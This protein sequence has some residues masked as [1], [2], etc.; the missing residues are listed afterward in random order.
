M[1][2]RGRPAKIDGNHS[3]IRSVLR[4]IGAMVVD[5]SAVGS[6][7]PDLMVLYRGRVRLLEVKD[8]NKPPSARRLTPDQRTWHQMAGA[9]GVCVHVVTNIDE[10]VM[11]T[12]AEAP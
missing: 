9:R 11:A 12:C 6:G 8:G 2:S 4:D 1:I 7:V 5:L 10:A 3:E